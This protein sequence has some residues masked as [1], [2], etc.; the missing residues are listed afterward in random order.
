MT[1]ERR[2]SRRIPADV[3][4]ELHDV[5]AHSVRGRAQVRN[6]SLGGMAVE[7]GVAL[8]PGETL[9][10]KVNVPIEFLGKVVYVKAR[11]DRFFYGIQFLHLGFFDKLRLRRYVTAQFKT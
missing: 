5:G 10:L 8:R 2:R 6:F 11:A 3:L 7:G 9:F 1:Q 4:L